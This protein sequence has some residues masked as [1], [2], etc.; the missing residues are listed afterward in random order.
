MPWVES[1]I[2]PETSDVIITSPYPSLALT[3][4]SRPEAIHSPTW[5]G[6]LRRYAETYWPAGAGGFVQGDVARRAEGGGVTF[7]G[8]SD[9][10]I[11]VN[12]NRVGTEQVE[13]RCLWAIEAK[14]AIEAAP[15]EEE[16]D[17]TRTPPPRGK[18]KTRRWRTRR[19]T[20]GARR[21]ARAWTRLSP[22][23]P[24]PGR[25]SGPARVIVSGRT[26]EFRAFGSGSRTAASSA[27]PIS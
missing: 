1:A 2:D 19:S 3:V 13:E 7:H 22:A 23:A 16:K 20:R 14:G 11:N 12:G 4:F 15:P 17:P 8:R 21:G 18:T 9:E 6:D 26:R 10:V 27:R 5:R 25:T 24:E